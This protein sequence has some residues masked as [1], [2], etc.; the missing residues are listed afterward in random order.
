MGKDKVMGS[1]TDLKLTQKN[2]RGPGHARRFSHGH[3]IAG[4]H[5]TEKK[6]AFDGGYLLRGVLVSLS[7][8][9]VSI[10]KGFD[11]S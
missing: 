8:K 11:A 1:F 10:T 6:S 2:A 9:S 7:E 3:Q 4:M 5:A